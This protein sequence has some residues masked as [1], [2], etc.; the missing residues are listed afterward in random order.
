ME[1]MLTVEMQIADRARKNRSE[2]MT[3]LHQFIDEKLLHE[4]LATLNKK[5][6]SGVDEETWIDYHKQRETRI[7]QLLAAFKS[8]NYRA[9]NIRRVYIPKDKG[10]LRPLGLP[11]VEDKVLQTAV[12]RVLRPVYE[13]IFYHSSY[14]FRPGKSQHQ[15]LEELTR[16]V[17]LEGKRYII[18]ADMQNYFGSINHQCLRDLLD[19]RIKDGV[20]RKMIDKWLKAGILD[21]GQLV[22]PTEGTPQGGSI[23]PLISN[24]YLHYVLDEWFY[25]QIRPLLKGDSFLIRF[26]DDFLLGFTNKEDALRVMHVLP[27]RLGKY[28]LMLH[29][30][31]TKLI[32]LTTK[33]GGPDQEKNTFDFLGFCHHMG[34]SRKGKCILKRKTSSKKLNASLNRMS[35]WIRN[36]RDKIGIQ[37]LL[38]GI[39]QKLRGH[40]VYYGITFNS[41]RLNSYYRQ[42]QRLLH[43]WLNR[44]G[45]KRVW[46]WE[47][48]IKLTEEWLPLER[49]RIY[50]NRL[51]ARP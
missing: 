18:D 46:I 42:T 31:K 13:D 2:A 16:Q 30:E 40:Y 27:K 34:F 24:V 25:Q 28:G 44:R 8:G 38:T 7:P 29:P 37:E 35:E 14:G 4:S 43:K 32:D 45:G 1:K 50:H 23:S 51:L 5:G 41:R 17:S 19:L 11:T 22:Y 12:T 39:N 21:N 49:P 20:I 33:K 9:P 26:A 15:A 10:K 36:N 6:A 47:K 3:N 48:I